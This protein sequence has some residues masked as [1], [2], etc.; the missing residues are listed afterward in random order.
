MNAPLRL[1]SVNALKWE[2]TTLFD[3]MPPMCGGNAF[4]ARELLLDR[5]RGEEASAMRDARLSIMGFLR[6]SWP[7]CDS[8]VPRLLEP[9]PSNVIFVRAATSLQDDGLIMYEA[10]LI[11]AGPEP[12][13]RDAL[14]TRRGLAWESEP[15]G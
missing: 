7:D 8:L 3:S 2:V 9:R 13:I 5:D 10:L 11:G 4:Q 12:Q 1:P 15:D 14:L 6:R